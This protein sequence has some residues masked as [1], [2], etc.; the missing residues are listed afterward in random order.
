MP[1]L[2]KPVLMWAVLLHPPPAV[3][4]FVTEVC[5]WRRAASSRRAG[6]CFLSQC[7]ARDVHRAEDTPGPDEFVP[8]HGAGEQWVAASHSCYKALAVITHVN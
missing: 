5:R 4:S 8:Q 2:L 3:A 6:I 7:F 1:Q